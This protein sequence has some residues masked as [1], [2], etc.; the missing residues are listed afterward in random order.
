M[1]LACDVGGEHLRRIRNAPLAWKRVPAAGMSPADSAVEPDGTASRSIT[2]GS[3]PASLAASAA[4]RPAAP[5]P[6]ISTGTS[7]SKSTSSDGCTLIRRRPRPAS[8]RRDA[9]RR[10]P[11]ASRRSRCA[12]RRDR[13]PPP[14]SPRRR[15][16]AERHRGRLAR[17]ILRPLARAR[18]R[19]PRRDRVDAHFRRQRLRQH[20]RRGMQRAL[21]QRVGDEVRRQLEHALIEDV[22]DRG[23]VARLRGERLARNSGARRF[24]AN[25]RSKRAAS[26][27]PIASGSN[28]AAL[29]TSRVSGPT[30]RPRPRPAPPRPHDRRGPPAP[31]R[32]GRPRARSR[33]ARPSASAT[34]LCAWIAT[35]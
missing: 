11:R 15:S 16:A 12:R 6:M 34:E 18:H 7:L 27:V 2:T 20:A 25:W 13:P 29:L 17:E 22:D 10:R 4:H 32:R 21:R 9:V 5:A 28:V 14:R 1:R 23:T 24:T 26:S 3:T 30:A 31:R 35:A 19:R 8:A 33:R